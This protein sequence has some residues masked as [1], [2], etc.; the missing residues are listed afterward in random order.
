LTVDDEGQIEQ[1]LIKA[2]VWIHEAFDE[3]FVSGCAAASWIRRDK[4]KQRRRRGGGAAA[5]FAGG[6][7]YWEKEKR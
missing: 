7:L 6:G 5:R 2:M 4:Q 1:A 3:A